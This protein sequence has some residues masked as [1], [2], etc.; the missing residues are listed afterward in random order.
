M[1]K[2][3]ILIDCDD[4]Q[5]EFVKP[6]LDLYN[7]KYDDN[8]QFD[9]ITDWEIHKFLKP[10]C[11]NIFQ[12]FANDTFIMDCFPIVNSVQVINRLHKRYDIIFLSAVYHS[13]V[14]PRFYKLS[15]MFNWYDWSKNTII[16]SRKDLIHGDVL[17]DDCFSNHSSSVKHSIL[18]D[19]PWNEKYKLN[20]NMYRMD[21]WLEIEKK[22]YELLD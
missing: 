8:L 12:E 13:N 6:L 9:D 17:I 14:S 2:K 20:S 11:K 19:R 7:K 5:T 16:A 4:T 3:T 15:S 1:N 21:N 10:T 18:F 22:I